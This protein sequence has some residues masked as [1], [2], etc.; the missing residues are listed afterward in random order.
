MSH[1]PARAFRQP[2]PH[3]ENDE[4]EDSADQKGCAPANL[5][6]EIGGIQ[7][8]DRAPC[9]ERR[10]DPKAA[11]DHQIRPAAY[12][13]RNELLN[14]RIDGS[15][16]PSDSCTGEKAKQRVTPQIP[17]ESRCGGGNEIKR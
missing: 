16:F 9:S 5:R 2:W 12:A 8:D 6:I 15:I 4:T 11:V 7:E 10:A 14:G 13:R 17:G 3:K 1:E